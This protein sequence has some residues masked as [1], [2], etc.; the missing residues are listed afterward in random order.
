MDFSG[1]VAFIGKLRR[2]NGK[3]ERLV[4]SWDGVAPPQR[5]EGPAGTEILPSPGPFINGRGGQSRS[6]GQKGEADTLTEKVGAGETD[7]LLSV[8]EEAAGYV[9]LSLRDIT[10]DV[11]EVEAKRLLEEIVS[12]SRALSARGRLFIMP[13]D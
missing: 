8:F 7:D 1:I 5:A 6:P 13:K 10:S 11:E 4:D 3:A 9:D 12:F 2:K